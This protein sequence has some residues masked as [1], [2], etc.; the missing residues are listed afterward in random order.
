MP[1]LVWKL[2]L[3]AVLLITLVA[4]A[5][6]RAPRQV[7][8]RNDMRRLVFSALALYAAGT[9]AWWSG[10]L[11]LA[12]TVYAAGIATAALGAWL[13]RGHDQDE[14]PAEDESFG[15]EPPPDPEGLRF[16]WEAFERDLRD[17]AE[18]SRRVRAGA[19]D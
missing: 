7:F 4:S 12:V 18:R 5:R 17:Y 14:P 1:V 3:T 2:T 15:D 19:S 6:A 13:S 16:D 10:H 9:L 8:P 11:S